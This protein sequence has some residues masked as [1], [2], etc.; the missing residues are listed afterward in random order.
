MGSI[1]AVAIGGALG[2]VAR[3]GLSILAEQ[4]LGRDF[5][6][7]IF[8]ANILG[9]VAIGI[10]FVL[11]VEKSG[12]SELWRSLLMVGFLG[13]FTTFSTFSLNSLAMLETGRYLESAIYILG[14]IILS[15]GGCLL[16]MFLTRQFT[17]PG[18]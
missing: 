16:G 7:G 13:G 14:S 2:S 6:Y 11:L 15:V 10:C 8:I 5:P 1:I 12:V 3:Y 18:V 4:S 9:S 17:S